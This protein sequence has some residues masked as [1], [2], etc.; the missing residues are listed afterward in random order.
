MEVPIFGDARTEVI[1]PPGLQ[2]G[3]ILAALVSIAVVVASTLLAEW[4][5]D[6]RPRRGATDFG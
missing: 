5:I 3:G 1:C 6:S 2:T 4:F